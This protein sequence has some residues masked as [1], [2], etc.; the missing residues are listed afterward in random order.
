VLRPIDFKNLMTRVIGRYPR[1]CNTPLT[2]VPMGS[3][4]QVITSS[5]TPTQPLVP[6]RLLALASSCRRLQTLEEHAYQHIHRQLSDTIRRGTRSRT[7]LAAGIRRLLDA[8][9]DTAAAVSRPLL[10]ALYEAAEAGILVSDATILAECRRHAKSDRSSLDSIGL[11]TCN[12]PEKLRAA[13]ASYEQNLKV[14]NRQTA[15]IVCDDS[16]DPSSERCTEEVLEAARPTSAGS[17]NFVGLAGKLQLIDALEHYAGAPRRTLE[18]GLLAPLSPTLTSA[19]ANRNAWL[20]LTAGQVALSTDDDEQC[21]LR[22]ARETKAGLRISSNLD[23]LRV[24]Y[25][26]DR[27]SACAETE[28]LEVDALGIFEGWIGRSSAS[29]IAEIPSSQTLLVEDCS[30]ELL[31][32]CLDGCGTIRLVLPGLIGDRGS[33]TPT[34]VLF[35]R[36]EAFEAL[37]ECDE[38]YCRAFR[39]REALRTVSQPTLTDSRWFMSGVYAIDNRDITLAFPPIGRNQDGVAGALF[40]SCASGC[41]IAHVPEAFLHAPDPRSFS[42]FLTAR[43]VNACSIADV[44]LAVILATS[45]RHI[46]WV[47]T[48][49]HLAHIGESLRELGRLPIKD[50]EFHLRKRVVEYRAMLVDY[51]ER[52]MRDV[53][54]VAS[55][56]E[57]VQGYIDKTYVAMDRPTFHLPWELVELYGGDQ[58]P[59]R[60]QEFIREMGEFLYWWPSLHQAAREMRTNRGSITAV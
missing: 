43:S 39:C 58:T 9:T 24:G 31:A 27:P 3:E 2:S 7:L 30:C 38:S 35:Y 12:R 45:S 19:G 10:K 26:E 16:S 13:L 6:T 42:S 55:W 59:V 11:L 60:L 18:F 21:Q 22:L 20:L 52:R 28:S 32:S 17:L 33:A 46:T 51:L 56:R 8:R 49:V 4:R 29:I 54:G 23:N 5:P 48:G 14:H 53:T 57:D 36:G 1:Y 47:S 37:L 50:F 34:E 44:L 25:F 15:I 40:T 41:S